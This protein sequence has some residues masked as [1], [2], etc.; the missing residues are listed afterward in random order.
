MRNKQVAGKGCAGNSDIRSIGE[1]KTSDINWVL[2]NEL[3]SKYEN[4]EPNATKS[5]YLYSHKK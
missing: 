5:L 3:R 4:L 1:E 2:E